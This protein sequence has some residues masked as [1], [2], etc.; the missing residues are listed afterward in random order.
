[1]QGECFASRQKL[2]KLL[3]TTL[4]LSIY[5]LF[6]DSAPGCHYYVKYY[7]SCCVVPLSMLPFSEICLRLQESLDREALQWKQVHNL[8]SN[9]ALPAMFSRFFFRPE[10]SLNVHRKCFAP[11]HIICCNECASRIS[12]QSWLHRHRHMQ[13]KFLDFLHQ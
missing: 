6:A 3:L 9:S 5:L 4:Q 2:K 10:K 8:L 12:P 7:L 11:E 13:S 1:M